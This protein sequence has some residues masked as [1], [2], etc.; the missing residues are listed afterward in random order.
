[1]WKFEALSLSLSQSIPCFVSVFMVNECEEAKYVIM[2]D[3]S[4]TKTLHKNQCQF[5]EQQKGYT[6]KGHSLCLL[7]LSQRPMHV[8]F[9]LTTCIHTY[10]HTYI[11]TWSLKFQLSITHHGNSVNP[12]RRRRR[13]RT[14]C[15][16]P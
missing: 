15:S 6:Q 12:R 11:H 14:W 1:M 4:F 3:I 7:F 2:K 8:P 10:I 16:R 9:S 5:L 13:R